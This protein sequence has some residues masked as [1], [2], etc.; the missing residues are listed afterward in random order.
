MLTGI[1][2]FIGFF[3]F[4][5]RF[6]SIK[7]IKILSWIVIAFMFVLMV[8][9]YCTEYQKYY[10]FVYLLIHGGSEFD[11]DRAAIT[12]FIINKNA[13]GMAMLMGIIFALINHWGIL[14][15]FSYFLI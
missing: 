6:K 1:F 15:V 14:R 11:F 12:S 7:F 5:K 10:D 8:Y 9:S 3:V 4:P 2:I 13:Y